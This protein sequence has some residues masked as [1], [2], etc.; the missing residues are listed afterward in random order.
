MWV[1]YNC[2]FITME[3]GKTLKMFQVYL[4][5]INDIITIFKLHIITIKVFSF[6]LE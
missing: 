5:D 2:L 1:S 6:I 3:V 4:F